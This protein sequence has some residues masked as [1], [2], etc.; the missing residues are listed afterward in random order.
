[1]LRVSGIQEVI[2]R[3]DRIY[4]RRLASKSLAN[5]KLKR[6]FDRNY[7]NTFPALRKISFDSV[8]VLQFCKSA[9][10]LLFTLFYCIFNGNESCCKDSLPA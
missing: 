10:I 4:I 1:M 9:L 8:R 3:D 5:K 2:R 6:V 7:V